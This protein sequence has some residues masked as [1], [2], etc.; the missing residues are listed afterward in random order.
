LK[1]IVSTFSAVFPQGSMWLVGGGDLLLIGAKTGDIAARLEAV[2]DGAR[3]SSVESAMADVGVAPGTAAFGLLS[4]FAGGPD[5]IRRFASAPDIQTDDRD[6]LEYSA[7]RAIY[8]RSGADNALIIRAL[9]AE[10]PRA[11]QAAFDHADDRDWASRGSM[12]L[13][14]QAFTTAY[15]SFRQAAQHN[16]RNSTALAGLSD[17]AGGAGRLAEEREWLES[18]VTREADNAP[19]RIELSRVL[20]VSGDAH[21]ALETASD[22]LRLAPDD[23]RAAEQLASVL[24]DT[25]DGQ[26]LT[27]FAEQLVSRF[28]ERAD[29][30]YYRATALYLVGRTA[31]AVA[32]A[33]QVVSAHPAHARAQGL[34]GAA[35]ASLGQRECAQAGFDQSINDNP[36]D[37]SA[38][39]NAGIFQ[40]RIANASAAAGYFASALALDPNSVPARSGLAQ[41]RDLTR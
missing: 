21:G 38:Y 15:E 28:P 29:S 14:A 35:C 25:G 16:P 26:R 8:G 19:A 12:D 3:R 9:A 24:A 32:A 34:L 7:P 40:L 33:R 4:L 17:A 20:A 27:A 18:V 1:S 10:R 39:I 41:A 11:V 36:R 30:G 6:G 31:D 13:R 22:A 37:A 2:A 23:P 5:D